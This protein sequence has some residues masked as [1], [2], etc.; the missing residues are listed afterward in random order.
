MFFIA[1]SRQVMRMKDQNALEELTDMIGDKLIDSVIIGNRSSK[2]LLVI[3]G[4]RKDGDWWR[5]QVVTI[6]GV[7]SLSTRVPSQRMRRYGQDALRFLDEEEYVS[8]V[9]IWQDPLNLSLGIQLLLYSGRTIE[10][11]GDLAVEI[12]DG[13]QAEREYHVPAEIRLPKP[14]VEIG[15]QTS[16]PV[17]LPEIEGEESGNVKTSE[18]DALTG[19][20]ERG[21]E[22]PDTEFNPAAA[23]EE[24]F[25][26]ET[27]GEPYGQES[28]TGEE[29]YE[30]VEIDN[31]VLE[32]HGDPEET[33]PEPPAPLIEPDQK[34]LVE[35]RTTIRMEDS[36]TD[37]RV[38][39]EIPEVTEE[40]S[41]TEVGIENEGNTE[42]TFDDM[43]T[44]VPR[45]E[46]HAEI[47]QETNN[48]TAQAEEESSLEEFDRLQT[49]SDNDE[50]PVGPSEGKGLNFDEA[51]ESTQ[52]KDETEIVDTSETFWAEPETDRSHMYREVPV[53]GEIEPDIIEEIDEKLKEVEEK[54]EGIFGKNGERPQTPLRPEDLDKL[55]DRLR[56]RKMDD[57]E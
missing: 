34:E 46:V 30:G 2:G 57:Q 37:P 33:L 35:E 42:E 56:R 23:P 12:I 28:M 20:Q 25:N 11:V 15:H 53:S 43:V 13:N 47:E 5:I 16:E 7:H 21:E 10:V 49:P 31:Q 3:K 32:E 52:L 50:Q 40:E 55:T 1:T 36:Q 24:R 39:Q 4:A 18:E 6:T 14:S 17:P 26:E 41:K 48:E 19:H 51:P 29:T 27:L 22:I 45:E 54:V 9:G 44:G 8:R 38:G